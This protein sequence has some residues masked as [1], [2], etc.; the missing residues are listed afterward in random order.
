MVAEPVTEEQARCK[1]GRAGRCFARDRLPGWSSLLGHNIS[2][3]IELL[4]D[5][6]LSPPF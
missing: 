4:Y 1:R 3:S 5:P 6:A 2:Q